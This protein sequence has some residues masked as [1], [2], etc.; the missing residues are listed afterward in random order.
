V[1][2]AFFDL[3]RTVIARSSSL[4]LA[5]AFR[6][7]GLIGRR[8]LLRAG[9]AQL[10]FTLLGVGEDA[11]R[12]LAERGMGVLAGVSVLEVRELVSGAIE[13]ALRPLVYRGALELVRRHRARGDRVYLVSAALDEIVEQLA[14]ELGFDGFLGS[15]CV[16]ENGFYTGRPAN[17]CYGAEKAAALE[18]LA[19]AARLDLARSAA[20]SDSASDLPFLE[21]VGRPVAVNPDRELRRIARERDWPVVR[22][23][24]RGFV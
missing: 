8:Q 3:D 17:L 6:G 1:R 23:R 12:E 24:R 19:A 13:P 16:T 4:A 9:L 21:A 2:A 5:S 18:R 14:A 20:Y 7:R 22:L 15:S 10:R 11:G